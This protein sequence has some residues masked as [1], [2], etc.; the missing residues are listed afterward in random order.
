MSDQIRADVFQRLALYGVTFS[1]V[2]RGQ[3]KRDAWECDSWACTFASASRPKQPEEFEFFTGLGL[4]AAPTKQ[5]E[6]KAKFQFPGVTPNDIARRTNYGRRYLAHLETLREPVAPHPADVLY[7][8]ILDSS[9]C[10]SS[11][12]EWCRDYGYSDDSIKARDTYDAC[13]RNTEKLRHI[14][15]RDQIRELS[16]T[17]QDY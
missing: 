1:A 9:A 4:R 8:V 14:L 16:E 5:A 17:L 10:E 3:T 6:M 13:Q 12:A 2:Y 7:S 15:T 11:F